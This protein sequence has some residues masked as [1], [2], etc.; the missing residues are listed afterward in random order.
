MYDQSDYSALIYHDHTSEDSME[1]DIC[2]YAG[3]CVPHVTV[4][5]ILHSSGFNSRNQ[6]ILC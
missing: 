6:I 2:V 4:L 5:L 3:V 1:H